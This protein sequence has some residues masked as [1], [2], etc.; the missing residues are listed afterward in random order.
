MITYRQSGIAIFWVIFFHA[1]GM[2]ALYSWYPHYDVLMHFGGGVAM[3]VLGLALWDHAIRS[4][5]F[6]QK[7]LWL[8]DVF[9]AFCIVGF[10]GLVGI[11]WEWFEYGFDAVFAVRQDWGLAQMGL[12]DTMFDLFMDL[13]GGLAVVLWRKL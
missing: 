7:K 6:T 10:V 13:A 1:L 8:R 12:G 11:A 5:T 2:F 4:I 3:G 9:F